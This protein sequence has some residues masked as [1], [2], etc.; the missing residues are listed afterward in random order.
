M[1]RFGLCSDGLSILVRDLLILFYGGRCTFLLMQ[2]GDASIN[3]LLFFGIVLVLLVL[4]LAEELGEEGLGLGDDPGDGSVEGLVDYCL[5]LP[6]DLED[7]AGNI[8]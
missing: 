3:F 5:D 2:C 6:D 4:F 1:R 7:F 8:A